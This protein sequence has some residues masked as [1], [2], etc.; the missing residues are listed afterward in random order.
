MTDTEA[1]QVF[2]L[3]RAAWPDKQLPD[4]TIDLW[5]ELATDLHVDDAKRAAEQIV[6]EDQWFPSIARFRQVC[7]VWAH[8]RRNQDAADRGLPGPRHAAPPPELLAAARELLAARE[9]MPDHDH[10]G[11]APCLV[12]GGVAPPS[13]K[14]GKTT[15]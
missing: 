12:C 13:T 3:L 11:P 4:K 2:G 14:K 5:L 10:R 7:E 8:R 6:R 1:A 9:V 15:P